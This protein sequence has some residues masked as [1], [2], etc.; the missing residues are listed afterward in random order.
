MS[1][2][3][4]LKS[5]Y[6][7]AIERLRAED[8]ERGGDEQKP[9]TEQQK[10]EMARLRREAKAK[11]A[12]LEIMLADKRAAAANDPEKLAEVQQHYEIDRGRVDSTLESAIRRV[13]RGDRCS[14]SFG[15]GLGRAVS[16]R[17][18]VPDPA[19]SVPWRVTLRQRA[20]LGLPRRLHLC[21]GA[22][23]Q[24]LRHP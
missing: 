1:D 5:A 22:E 19:A 15:A 13:R 4:E 24:Q 14:R 11:L 23:R 10:R 21:H 2:E 9:L 7:L 12:E 20:R 17:Q 18:S 3:Q 6:E 8:R 16:R